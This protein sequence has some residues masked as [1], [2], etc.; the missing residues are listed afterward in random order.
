M[1]NFRI[2]HVGAES[3][4]QKVLD[5]CW[6]RTAVAHTSKVAIVRRA[7]SD[8]VRAKEG[9]YISHSVSCWRAHTRVDLVQSGRPI[10]VDTI[11]INC[12]STTRMSKIACRARRL[13][14][15]L[16]TRAVLAVGSV[17]FVLAADVDT[18][19]YV[20]HVS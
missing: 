14:S 11:A 2:H 17:A 7:C 4:S 19:P 6:G 10:R 9:I 18:A 15:A 8:V 12:A 1:Y 3:N 20:A 5:I 16:A 13:S